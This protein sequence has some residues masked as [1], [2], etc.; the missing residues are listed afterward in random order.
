MSPVRVIFLSD[1]DI[2][3]FE[4]EFTARRVVDDQKDTMAIWGKLR[5]RSE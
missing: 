2:E 1:W 4:K 5:K 3:P